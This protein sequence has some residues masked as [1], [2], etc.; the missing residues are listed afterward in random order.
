MRKAARAATAGSPGF[1]ATLRQTELEPPE[2][3]TPNLELGAL[4]AL[5]PLDRRGRRRIRAA[6]AV[7]R[8]RGGGLRRRL[9]HLLLLLAAAAA[10]GT[11][12]RG[13]PAAQLARAV[14]LPPRGTVWRERARR[15]L[16]V[17]SFTTS[18][19]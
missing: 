2:P 17:V 9:V 18:S 10:R 11:D 4:A 1:L 6:A 14:A 7:G 19:H 12:L 5:L 16:L 8:R 13:V 3:R 15:A